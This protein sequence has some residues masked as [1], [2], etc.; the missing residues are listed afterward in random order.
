MADDIQENEMTP[1]DSVDYVRG[2]KG[3]DSILISISNMASIIKNTQLLNI[4]SNSEYDTGVSNYGIYQ[5]DNYTAGGSAVFLVNNYNT[6]IIAS[7]GAPFGTAIGE[8]SLSL[9]KK[10]NNGNIFIRNNTAFQVSIGFK[11]V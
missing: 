11:R 8:G 5:L 6:L 10:E 7:V 1:V 3:K 2:L 4:E 9:Y